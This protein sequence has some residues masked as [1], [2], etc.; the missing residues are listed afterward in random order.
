MG[1]QLRVLIIEDSEDRAILVIQELI[2]GGYNPV[3]KRVNT[4]IALESA[5]EKEKWDIVFSNSSVSHF[6]GIDALSL[7]RK[8]GF[9]MPFFLVI[10]SANESQAVDAMKA[11]AND[12]FI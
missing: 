11:G 9:D 8:K 1:T 3:Y 5:L 12:Y 4:P 10:D 7:L 2:R 6:S